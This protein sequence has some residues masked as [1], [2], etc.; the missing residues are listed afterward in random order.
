[1]YLA[2]PIAGTVR[3]VGYVLWFVAL[4]LAVWAIVRNRPQER[5][6]DP[7]HR[8]TAKPSSPRRALD[9]EQMWR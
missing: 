9:A 2:D 8:P 4:G 5:T 7:T 6:G 1:V 3:T